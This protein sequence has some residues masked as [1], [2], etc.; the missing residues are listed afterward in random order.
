MS[1]LKNPLGVSTLFT[2]KQQVIKFVIT[3]GVIRL[4]NVVQ[5]KVG[6]QLGI[7]RPSNIFLAMIYKC[8]YKLQ[9]KVLIK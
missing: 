3:V 6:L 8:E 5:L 7:L 9:F 2:Q 4:F 1:S